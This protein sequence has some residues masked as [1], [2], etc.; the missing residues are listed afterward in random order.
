MR[1]RAAKRILWR[2]TFCFDVGQSDQRIEYNSSES[3]RLCSL[4]CPGFWREL[5]NTLCKREFHDYNN[6]SCEVECNNNKQATI[7][8]TSVSAGYHTVT[9]KRLIMVKRWGT[10]KTIIP[11]FNTR[12]NCTSAFSAAKCSLILFPTKDLYMK[13]TKVK[14]YTI[15][16]KSWHSVPTSGISFSFPEPV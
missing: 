9:R 5:L 15:S 10:H 1:T 6:V 14:V 13:V 11:S 2:K 12:Q 7:R 4:P 3:S 16:K 8:N